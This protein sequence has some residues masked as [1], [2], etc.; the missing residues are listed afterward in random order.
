MMKILNLL[1]IDFYT[2][3][4]FCRF[5]V[6]LCGLKVFYYVFELCAL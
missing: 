2:N 3:Q 4:G 6:D 1:H 5:A